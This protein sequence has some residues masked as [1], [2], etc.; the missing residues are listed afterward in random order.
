MYPTMYPCR[1]RSCICPCPCP[2]LYPCISVS[3]M[4][5]VVAAPCIYSLVRNVSLSSQSAS[6]RA[7]CVPCATG[8]RYLAPFLLRGGRPVVDRIAPPPGIHSKPDLTRLSVS[9]SAVTVHTHQHLGE[10]YHLGFV[11]SQR[12]D[13]SL[14]PI[15]DKDHPRLSRADATSSLIMSSS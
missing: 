10:K 2:V 13:R 11:T 15:E 5:D 9:K 6:P 3:C 12:R 1:C 8:L 4:F 14:V 7:K